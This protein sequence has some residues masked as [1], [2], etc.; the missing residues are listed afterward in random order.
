MKLIEREDLESDP[1]T[2]VISASFIGLANTPRLGSRGVSTQALHQHCA[3][4]WTRSPNSHRQDWMERRHGR[5][6]LGRSCSTTID[7]VSRSGY[8]IGGSPT[9][10][11]RRR[12]TTFCI[13]SLAHWSGLQPYTEEVSARGNYVRCQDQGV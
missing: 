2:S 8:L 13:N 9:D 3:V 1:G 5:V 6:C 12:H 7:M 11:R 10:P 4:L